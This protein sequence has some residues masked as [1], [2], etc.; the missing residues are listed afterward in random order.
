MKLRETWMRTT[1]K[2]EHA[3][4]AEAV[5]EA[6]VLIRQALAMDRAQFFA[7][8]NEELAPNREARISRL[9]ERRMAGEPLA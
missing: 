7:A 5:I 8:L 2:L 9:V 1:A 3:Q 4:I 6:E